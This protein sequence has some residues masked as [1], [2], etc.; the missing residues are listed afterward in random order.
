LNE[1]LDPIILHCHIPKTAGTTVSAG[2]R[3]SFE[4]LHFHH[5]H[6]D[7]FYILTREILERLLEIDP[8]LKSISS[9]HLRSFPLSVCDRPTFLITFLR[10]PED[11]FIS[12][13][14][15]VQRNF[16][17]FPTQ[18]QRL[19]P[20]ETPKLPLR[21]LARQYLDLTT[22]Y[23]DLSPQTRFFCNPNTT[24]K[25]GLSDGNAYGLDSY[26]IARAILMEFHFVGIVDE[27]KKSLELL[28]DLLAQRG[29]RVY[30]SSVDRQNS[31]PEKARPTWM[32]LEDEVG[33]RVLETSKSDTLLYG[34]FREVLL[35]L[36]AKLRERCWLGFGP[37]YADA[38]DAFRA[39]RGSG[40]VRSLANSARLFRNGQRLEC[41]SPRAV[42]TELSCDLLEERAA[43]AFAERNK[44]LNATTG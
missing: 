14:K 10:K 24:A 28:T 15:Y 27:M 44:D 2:L 39:N 25:L 18:V 6:P 32:T 34:H 38:R 3:N 4:I 31:C 19:W 43:R 33:C 7:P 26:E 42:V 8:S 16:H 41:S 5:F 17:T 21:E 1:T 40:A 12:Q 35:A 30:L 11:A 37:A 13:L 20:S 36:H 22:S 29:V 23:Q 9:H